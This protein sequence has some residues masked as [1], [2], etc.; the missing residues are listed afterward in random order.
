LARQK[1]LSFINVFGL[2]VGLACFTLFLLYAVNEFNFDGFH[3]NAKNIY[4][5]YLHIDPINGEE[6]R[7]SSYLPIPLGPAMKQDLPEIENFVRIKDS[8]DENFIKA[9]NKVTRGKL[10]AADPQFF[11]VFSFKIIWR[12]KCNWKNCGDKSRRE[13]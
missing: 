2:S 10:T 13:F 5:V 4:R 9:D 7:S 3:K 8:W 12:S 11:S 1:G 6:A